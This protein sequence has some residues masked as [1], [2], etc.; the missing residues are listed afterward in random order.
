MRWRVRTIK[1]LTPIR[2]FSVLRNE[3]NTIQSERTARS[4]AGTHGGYYA[5]TDCP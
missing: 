4:W 3:I 2:H 5:I 1:V